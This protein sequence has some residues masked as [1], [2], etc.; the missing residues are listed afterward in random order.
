MNS[1]EL[2]GEAPT[3]ASLVDGDETHVDI[4]AKRDLP[5]ITHTDGMVIVDEYFPKSAA[6]SRPLNGVVL[7]E[8]PTSV[9]DTLCQ[10]SPFPLIQSYSP[11]ALTFHQVLAQMILPSKTQTLSMLRVFL[12]HLYPL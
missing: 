10:D 1:L 12:R 9:A 7:D 6:D 3:I 8:V 4:A 5:T 11:E 2:L